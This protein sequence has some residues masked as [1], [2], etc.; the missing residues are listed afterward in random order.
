MDAIQPQTLLSTGVNG[1]GR[2]TA[3]LTIFGKLYP[4]HDSGSLWLL[5][6]WG[7]L[8]FALM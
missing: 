6:T 4:F 2:I 8:P 7:Q 5:I 3:Q 1:I